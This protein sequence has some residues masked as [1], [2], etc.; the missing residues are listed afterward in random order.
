MRTPWDRLN[1]T[2]VAIN[3]IDLATQGDVDEE[4][5]QLAES[6]KGH[7]RRLAQ[8]YRNLVMGAPKL[9]NDTSTAGAHVHYCEIHVTVAHVTAGDERLGVVAD[10]PWWYSKVSKSDFDDQ[11]AGLIYTTRAPS[12]DAALR[13]IREFSEAVDAI[14]GKCIRMKVEEVTF[15]TKH[16]DSIS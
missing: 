13:K 16:G 4:R 1:E 3:D 6:A 14:G 2:I 5:L 9:K 15:D 12:R 11:S 8:N 7:L 10:T